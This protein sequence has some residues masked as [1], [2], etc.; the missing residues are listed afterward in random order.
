MVCGW[1]HQLLEKF[2]MLV[3]SRE[4]ASRVS[5]FEDSIH[6][7]TA[8]PSLE[9]PNL[10]D[11]AKLVLTNVKLTC[12]SILKGRLTDFNPNID[13]NLRHIP[14]LEI[15]T[16]Y[17]D[18]EIHKKAA[19]LKKQTEGF[20]KRLIDLF[21]KETKNGS[22]RILK[23]DATWREQ[24]QSLNMDLLLSER[25]DFLVR[26]Y[27]LT[28]GTNCQDIK[29]HLKTR[30][31]TNFLRPLVHLHRE[32]MELLIVK[33][34][35]LQAASLHSLKTTLAHL[36]ELQVPILLKEGG[37]TNPHGLFFRSPAPGQAPVSCERRELVPEQPMLVIECVF[38]QPLHPQILAQGIE[39][40]GLIEAVLANA[41]GLFSMVG[42]HAATVREEKV[43][44]LPLIKEKLG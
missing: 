34:I 41:N 3:D 30:V 33:R 6:L 39:G 18:F 22:W 24:F 20:L 1:E 43:F 9:P 19:V 37:G 14:A 15:I 42:L 35:S 23:I 31:S 11:V 32:R 13:N 5:I 4:G 21:N 26:A 36:C 8:R 16:G 28:L 7:L 29:D 10:L 27:F 25:M 38:A 2:Y 17:T 40:M 12:K 44:V